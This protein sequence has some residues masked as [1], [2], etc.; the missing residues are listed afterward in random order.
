M[1]PI[2]IIE[3]IVSYMDHSDILSFFVQNGLD[4]RRRFCVDLSCVKRN[5]E[6][7]KE[8]MLWFP[9]VII[10]GVHLGTNSK[11]GNDGMFWGLNMLIISDCVE[12]VDFVV[13]EGL[14]TLVLNRCYY[15]E[16]V[17]GGKLL[18]TLKLVECCRVKE[19]SVM[20]MLCR[21]ELHHCYNLSVV[22]K[23]SKLKWFRMCGCTKMKDFCMVKDAREIRSVDCAWNFMISSLEAFWGIVELRELHLYE[24]G[25]VT[26]VESLGECVNLRVLD[27]FRCCKVK[28]LE[29]LGKLRKMRILRINNCCQVTNVQFLEKMDRLRMLDLSGCGMSRLGLVAGALT[30][31][32]L[33]YCSFLESLDGLRY[34]FVEVINLAHCRSL[35]SVGE[36]RESTKLKCMNLMGCGDTFSVNAKEEMNQLY[37]WDYYGIEGVVDLFGEGT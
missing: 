8:L 22:G 5:I 21:L 23:Q 2:V 15:L 6:F 1:I 25:G 19:L 17:C 27:L 35:I 37:S 31:V 10:R 24:C 16:N 14:R 33:S 9:N 18:E 11:I 20:P 3:I 34:E 30:H 36:M 12:L 26:N 13:P 7:V 29:P 32:D 4:R 28:N